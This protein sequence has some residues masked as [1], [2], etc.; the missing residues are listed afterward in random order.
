MHPLLFRM[1]P[2]EG[3]SYSSQRY[4]SFPVGFPSEDPLVHVLTN[5]PPVRHMFNH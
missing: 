4:V 2:G 5:L 1:D 3:L